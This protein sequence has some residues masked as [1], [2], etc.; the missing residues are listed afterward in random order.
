MKTKHWQTAIKSPSAR[1]GRRLRKY[2]VQPSN[3]PT[4]LHLPPGH[5]V[6][7]RRITD[8][9]DLSLCASAYRLSIL[10]ALPPAWSLQHAGVELPK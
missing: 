8:I 4:A 2:T 7:A 9:S 1:P 5:S 6:H 3:R 10:V